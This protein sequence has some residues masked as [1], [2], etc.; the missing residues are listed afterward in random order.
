MTQREHEQT[1]HSLRMH[2]L[3]YEQIAAR[4]SCTADHARQ[5][6]REHW[7]ACL[8]GEGRRWP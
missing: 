7:Q 8:Q 1:A 3:T 2:G 5:L 4:L 6:V